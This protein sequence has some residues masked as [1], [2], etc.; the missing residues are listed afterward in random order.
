MARIL[1]LTDGALRAMVPAVRGVEVVRQIWRDGWRYN[2]FVQ[3][4]R[5]KSGLVLIC[6]DIE[7]RFEVVDGDT[8]T[9]KQ[10]DVF[11][12]PRG[13]RYAVSFRGGREKSR[14]DSY[15]LH[16]DLF[17]EAGEELLFGDRPQ[18]LTNDST[19]RLSA[20]AE[21]LWRA[22]HLTD[23]PRN[24]LKIQAK[25]LSF[26]D[27]LIDGAAERDAGLYPIRAGVEALCCEWDRNE[28]MSRYAELCGVCESYFYM[29]FKSWAGVSP[30]EYRNRI[31]MTNAGTLLINTD[32][33][34][35]EV[36]GAV[37]FEDPFYFSRVFRR[38]FGVS[39]LQYRKGAGKDER[40]FYHP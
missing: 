34:V 7:G 14:M 19:G 35:G 22:V 4:P 31:R 25:F 37:G 10:G 9:V 26:L 33:S 23:N 32:L 8:V 30:V 16:F 6:A 2:G 3:T 11:F 12:A 28:H 39:P 38:T 29:L 5:P 15:T 20:C 17:D 27:E 24:V 40:G 18:V 21:A 13:S 1:S 36:A